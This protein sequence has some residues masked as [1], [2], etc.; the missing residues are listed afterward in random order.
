MKYNPL[1][2]YNDLPDLPPRADLETKVIMKKIITA[3][4]ALSELKGAIKNLPNPFLFID[5]VNLQEAQASSAIENIITT[6]DDLFQATVA[7]KKIESPATKEVLHYK[8]ALWFGFEQIKKKPLLTTNLFIA[9]M[10]IIKEN[11]SGIRNLPGTQLKNPATEKTVYTPP[12]G[13]NIIRNKLKGLEYFINTD[14]DID[15][16]VKMALIHYQ[17]E[18][19]HPFFDGNGRTGRIILLLYLKIA[20][21]TDHPS[22]YL[23]NYILK[24]K[25]EYYTNLRNVTEKNNWEAWVLYMLDMIEITSVNSRYRI[26]KIDT[27]MKTMGE[28]IQQQLPK[29]YTKDLVEVLFRLPYTKR[30]FLEAAGLGNIKTS[31]AYL[32]SLEEKGFLK[33]ITAGKEKLYL[34]FQL[35]DILKRQ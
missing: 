27:L 3:S 7:E 12:E 25:N 24:N 17:F 6:Q 9:L 18:A 13:E 32:K 14:D 33:S 34:N 1:K 23:S 22:L 31:G 28:K 21:L 11:Q 5:T 10:R 26:E 2:P 19:I 15:P 8:D 20:G 16:L 4:R 29:I 35:M 30:N